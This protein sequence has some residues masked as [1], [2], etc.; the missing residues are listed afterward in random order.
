[1]DERRAHQLS[2]RLNDDFVGGDAN[3]IPGGASAVDAAAFV[4]SV[5][6]RPINLN[7]HLLAKR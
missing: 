2:C 6:H 3:C 4:E 7:I 1:M 5:R